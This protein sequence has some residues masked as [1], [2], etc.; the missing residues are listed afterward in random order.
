MADEKDVITVELRD[1]D[2]SL[3]RLLEYIKGNAN[4]GHSYEVIVDPDDKERKK[5]FGI[6]GDGPFY[7]FS[8][9]QNGKEVEVEKDRVV[10]NYLER[11]QK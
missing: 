6:D 9:K 10:E 5:S 1:P 4:I 7:I 8:I 3:V 2:K 11:V